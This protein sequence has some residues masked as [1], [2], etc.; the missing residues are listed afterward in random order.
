MHPSGNIPVYRFILLILLLYFGYPPCT[1]AQE[2]PPKPVS[3]VTFQN[4]SFGAFALGSFG[5]TVTVT[6]SGIRSS[7]GDVILLNLGYSYGPALFEADANPGTI[8]SLSLGPDVMLSGSNGGSL[9][10]HL[11]DPSPGYSFVTSVTP[12]T[13]TQIS[14]G[15]TLTVGSPAANPAGSYSGSFLVIV[16]QE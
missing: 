9:L 6:A 10:L 14:V 16:N 1:L 4:M 2:H 7:T 15:G 13:T 11:E 8:I 12:P 3:L 5:G